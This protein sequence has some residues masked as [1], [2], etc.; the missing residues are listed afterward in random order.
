M[1]V[2]D[3]LIFHLRGS[4]VLR[5]SS[6]GFPPPH[7]TLSKNVKAQS[8][9]TEYVPQSTVDSGTR[10][11]DRASKLQ[12]QSPIPAPP[13]LDDLPVRVERDLQGFAAAWDERGDLH[14][15]PDPDRVPA[16]GVSTDGCRFVE[17]FDSTRYFPGCPCRENDAL[18]YFPLGLC[19]RIHVRP[20]F[21]RQ[22]S[23][24]LFIAVSVLDVS[25]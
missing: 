7:L 12:E 8:K 21:R 19:V 16:V 25:G 13:D 14:V 5:F 6:F 2:V 15:T 22:F 9:A 1:G 20:R 18:N 4:F 11:T 23:F 17:Q 3:Y 10:R 24:C